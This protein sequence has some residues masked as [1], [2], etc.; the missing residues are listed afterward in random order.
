LA[1]Y[2]RV[3]F[4]NS[5]TYRRLKNE[6]IRAKLSGKKGDRVGKKVKNGWTWIE[7][8]IVFTN[9]EVHITRVVPPIT[10][11]TIGALEELLLRKLAPPGLKNSITISGGTPLPCEIFENS[12]F[13]IC[14]QVTILP[15][16]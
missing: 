8:V 13:A 1:H 16:L 10:G 15:Y 2:I 11:E 6:R 4:H 14:S 3:G 12:F 7:G 9:P 5:I